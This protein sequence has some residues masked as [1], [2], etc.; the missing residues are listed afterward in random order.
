MCLCLCLYLYCFVVVF[1]VLLWVATDG[2]FM[3]T[4]DVVLESV[5][6]S[7]ARKAFRAWLSLDGNGGVIMDVE[8]VVRSWR[9]ASGGHRR[10]WEAGGVQGMV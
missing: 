6:S 10:S 4:E 2:V 8:G 7:W 1:S 9:K 5:G 3:D